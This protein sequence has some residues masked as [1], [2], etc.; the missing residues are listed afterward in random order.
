MSLIFPKTKNNL[1]L[2]SVNKNIRRDLIF[3]RKINFSESQQNFP[4]SYKIWC[5]S[6][7]QINYLVTPSS[8]DQKCLVVPPLL[9]RRTTPYVSKYHHKKVGLSKIID[10]TKATRSFQMLQLCRKVLDMSK[11]HGQELTLLF[12]TQQ[13]RL[14]TIKTKNVKKRE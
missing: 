9:S 6:K 3:Y 7:H 10:Y 11:F 14:F 1:S 13:R 2:L 8:S 4:C 5:I 12:H